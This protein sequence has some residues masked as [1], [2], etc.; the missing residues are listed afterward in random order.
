M[1]IGLI[2]IDAKIPNL[3]LMKLSAYFKGQGDKVELTSPLF[4]KDFDEIFASKIF[5]YTVKPILPEKAILGGSGYSLKTCL[6]NDVEYLMPDY[7][8]YNCDYAM[9]FASRG[10]NRNCPFCIVPKKEGKW[11]VAGDIYQFWNGQKRLKLLDNSLNTDEGFFIEIVKQF[12]NEQIEVDFSQGLDIRHLTDKQVFYLK[13][14]K[15]WKRIHF[16][17]D[18]MKT[19]KAVRRGVKILTKY[20]LNWQS[21]FYVLIGFN[22][23]LEEDLY[24]VNTLK[25]LNVESFA[26]PYDK[27]NCY[28]KDFTRWV[29]HKAI[30]KTV[31]WDDYKSNIKRGSL[32]KSSK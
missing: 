25:G 3:A 28:Q 11:R 30:F 13:Q 31:S 15:L 18:L 17:W 7:S 19:E 16:A 8:L 14:I 2:D 21:T 22:T 23:N 27:Y 1:K 20:K 6:D 12:I 29:N 32:F 24:R 4:A 26:M 10:C 5:N 9:G